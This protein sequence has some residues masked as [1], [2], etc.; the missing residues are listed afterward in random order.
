M[1]MALIPRLRMVRGNVLTFP[2]SRFEVFCLVIGDIDLRELG[3]CSGQ[4]FCRVL[5]LLL[6]TAAH[7][8]MS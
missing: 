4:R 1:Q 5:L 6:P 2:T 7:W 8:E 3:V